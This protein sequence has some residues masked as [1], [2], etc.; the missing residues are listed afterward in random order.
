MSGLAQGSASGG[1]LVTD[2]IGGK[3]FDSARAHLL[4]ISPVAIAIVVLV[5]AGWPL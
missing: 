5:A 3:R 1:K 2:R 4:W